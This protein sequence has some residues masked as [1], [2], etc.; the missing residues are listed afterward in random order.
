[1]HVNTYV[2]VSLRGI[3]VTMHNKE[4]NNTTG[5]NYLCHQA[6]TS[7]SAQMQMIKTPITKL[8]IV[9]Y[10]EIYVF[11]ALKKGQLDFMHVKQTKCLSI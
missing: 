1:M 4:S 5:R 8:V 10:A 6:S 2:F 11:L 7:L 9:N 3:Q